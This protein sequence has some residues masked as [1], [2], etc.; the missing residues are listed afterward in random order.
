MTTRFGLFV[1]Q[2][3]KMDLAGFSD[4]VEQ[5]EAMTDVAKKADEGSWDSI[6]LFDHFHTV[7]EPSTE[8]TFECWTTTAALARDTKRVNIGQM[9]GCN[10]YRNPA[11]YAKIAST[12]DVA[13]H[14]RLYAGIGAG[15]YEHEWK[16]YGYEWPE[17]KDRMGAFREATEII[18]KMWTE[19][20]P[21][22]KGKYYSIDKPINE[23][24][25]VRKPHPSL[26]IGGGGPN[27]TL[28]LVAKY[29][30]AANIG[31]GN[32]EVIK[33]KAAIL[34]GHCETIGRDYDE[35]IKST[36]INAFPIDK[37]DDPKK[38]TAKALGPM[39]WEKFSN[40]NLIGTEDEIADKVEAALEAGAD[41]VIFYVPG[42][43]YDLDLVTRVEQV[44][45]RFA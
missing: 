19:D 43:A 10:G 33:E 42:V 40:D 16:A 39:N 20:E 11:L 41:Y 25:G 7:P 1:P 13:S 21:V 2:G 37:G 9:V 15:W 17:L 6:W 8:S 26:W 27:V 30:D 18:Y 24:K 45:K 23:P 28:K 34:K 5:W 12:V 22:F 31:G 44:A 36:G 35:I 4:P 38:A 29:G 14:G 32:P 3:W